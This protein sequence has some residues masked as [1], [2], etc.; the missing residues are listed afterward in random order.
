MDRVV[1][2]LAG[3][4]ASRGSKRSR[5]ELGAGVETPGAGVER[6]ARVVRAETVEQVQA[7]INA[8]RATGKRVRVAG[9]GHSAPGAVFSSGHDD[10]PIVLDGALRTVEF[11][12]CD[13]TRA[14]ISV[15]G[16]CNL[17]INPSDPSSTRENSLNHII[18]A[19]GYAL[20]V[21]GGISHQT[22]AGFLQ[23]SSAGGSLAH[24]FADAIDWI[25][26]V[27]GLGNL[28]RF[29]RGTDDFNAAGVAVGLFGVVT[30]VGLT[31]EPQYFV[32]GEEINQAESQSLL[33]HDTSGDYALR[34][35]L[36]T[37]EYLHLNWFPQQRVRRVTQWTGFRTSSV[38]NPDPYESELRT[39]LTNVLA[40]VVL[41]LTSGFLA[42]DPDG[43]LVQKIVG[44]L[45]R[46][47]V[48]LD[49]KETF[50]DRWLAVLPCDDQ[51]RVDTL[52]KVV[53]T[54]I[55]LPLDQLSNA[56]DRLTRLVEDPAV[57]SNIIVE[58]YGAKASPF[59]LSPS[60]DRDVV[61]V[62]VFWWAHNIGSAR[63]H[64]AQFWN[65]LLELP[66]AR[67]HWGKHLPDVGST[68]GSVTFNP[69]LLRDRYPRLEDW[70]RIR[71]RLDPDGVFLSEY[72]RAI[73]GA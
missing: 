24:G 47:F 45:L 62:D 37:N 17:G 31:I 59:W 30:R 3:A 41:F 63:R 65:V 15:G 23:T 26:L 60:F 46:E 21:L 66:G 55:W 10:F 52:V 16:G 69:A 53:F 61:R 70:L 29:E 68:Y 9:A 48:P 58:L 19:R 4:L 22:I 8:A 2:G 11:E 73:L 67:L 72:W 18:D 34:S 38:P 56:L 28:Q 51:A 5:D 1:A 44:S 39:K 54:E 20:P 43:S 13:A 49:R 36:R 32:A 33:R 57:A 25:E 6:R 35:A 7:V 42:L 71:Q 50:N 64:F 40:A 12:T 14:R 27:D